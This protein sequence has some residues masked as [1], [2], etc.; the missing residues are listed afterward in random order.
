MSS[1]LKAIT[2]FPTKF[3]ITL[4]REKRTF[5][6]CEKLNAT[7]SSLALSWSWDAQQSSGIGE[8][9][10]NTWSRAARRKQ[11]KER[12]QGNGGMEVDLRG[13]AERIALAFRVTV[14]EELPATE[15]TIRWL[16]GADT[17][18][19]ESFCGWL[20]KTLTGG[21]R[22]VYRFAGTQLYPN[23]SGRSPTKNRI[24]SKKISYLTPYQNPR[25]S[26]SELGEACYSISE[27]R[28]DV[29]KSVANLR[30]QA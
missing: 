8:T 29:P 3:A 5:S 27:R 20:R 7:L 24:L 10:D 13:K 22:P 25:T 4:S 26:V 23:S 21:R 14:R 9:G 17:L 11:Q 28:S 6:I 12:Q 15:V 30:Y 2:P 19:W 1:S 16:R 18:I